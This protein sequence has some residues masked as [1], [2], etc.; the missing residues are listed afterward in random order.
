MISNIEFKERHAIKIEN[1]FLRV[2]V[3]PELG[4]KIASIF[5]KDKEFELLFQNKEQV[6]KTPQLYSSFED[7]DA[8]GFD[9]A[10][11]TIDES[12][13]LINGKNVVYPDHGE[14]WTAKFDDKLEN[15]KIILKYKSAIL[16]YDYKKTIYL[17]GDRV[18]AEYIIIN[19]GETE[20]PCI[21]A[22]HCL[23]NCEK[24]MQLFFPEGTDKVINVHES[25]YLGEVS[26][27]HSYPV[28]KDENG[29]N[30]YLDRVLDITS[31]NE[32]KY[33]AHGAVKD[34]KC[35]AYYPSKDVMYNVYFD[36]EKLP[37]VGFWVTEGGFR[38]D[39]NCALEPANGYYDTI[40]IASREGKILVLKP[41]E[42]LEFRIEI[43]LK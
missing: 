34:G 39:Y 11:P 6:Y 9:D 42:N 30:I 18:I 5:R 32:E 27:V 3:I 14:I 17:Q 8:S 41:K 43:E 35:G 4:G 28:T 20:F 26:K 37:Y 21:W 29:N 25:K 12:N 31:D 16:D 13:V 7:F 2:I 19:Y 40:D 22:M 10:F 1:D 24:D 33:Y 15:E 36:K 38:G 23:I